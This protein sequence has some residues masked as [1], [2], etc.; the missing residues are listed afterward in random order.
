MADWTD[1]EIETLTQLKQAGHSFGQIAAALPGRSRNQVA[2]KCYRL[3]LCEE[4]PTVRGRARN[5]PRRGR[6]NL[7]NRDNYADDYLAIDD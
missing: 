3:G 7:L 1:D 2:G 4:T 6:I 5:E